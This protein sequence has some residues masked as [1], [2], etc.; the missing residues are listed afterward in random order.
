MLPDYDYKS[1]W[2]ALR[3]DV[4]NI[5]SLPPLVLAD[6][7]QQPSLDSPEVDLYQLSA[8]R[9]AHE[10]DFAKKAVRT[11][12]LK[13]EHSIAAISVDDLPLTSHL[14]RHKLAKRMHESLKS[15]E[16]TV[17]SGTGAIRRLHYEGKVGT[18][19]AGNAANAKA[20]ANQRS[21]AVCLFFHS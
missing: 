10:T 12:S 11:G 16:D 17:G 7:I 4:A 3:Q 13:A 6:E 2:A 1:D 21:S 19:P 8:M 15:L 14:A 20:A 18:A 5:I 9:I